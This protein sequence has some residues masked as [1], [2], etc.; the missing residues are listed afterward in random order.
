[1]V[2]ASSDSPHSFAMAKVTP[3]TSNSMMSTKEMTASTANPHGKRRRILRSST[4]R[5]SWNCGICIMSTGHS[6]EIVKYK[7]EISKMQ[8]SKAPLNLKYDEV[9]IKRQLISANQMIHEPISPNS[10]GA[11]CSEPVASTNPT[12]I[13]P[14][15]AKNR[16]IPTM[17]AILMKLGRES[18]MQFMK[19][20][21]VRANTTNPVTKHA[22]IPPKYCSEGEPSICGIIPYTNR[23]I[24]PIRA[25]IQRECCPKSHRSTSPKSTP[26]RLHTQRIQRALRH[27]PE[28]A[29]SA[30]RCRPRS[31][32]RP[33]RL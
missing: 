14:M 32:T 3:Q 11:P 18:T 30:T 17:V 6:P 26:N 10:N 8:S 20:G 31:G 29:D 16:P 27:E 12:S 33:F 1:M 2:L 7:M 15:K 21:I 4:N 19:P 28:P 22:I 23:R 24:T 13:I 5:G 25:H 9:A